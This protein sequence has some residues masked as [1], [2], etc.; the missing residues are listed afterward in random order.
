MN[1]RVDDIST[2]FFFKYC[3]SFLL[4]IYYCTLLNTNHSGLIIF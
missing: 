2:N 4:K 3:L 1:A